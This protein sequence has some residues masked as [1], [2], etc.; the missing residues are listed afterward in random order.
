MKLFGIINQFKAYIAY[1]F[2]TIII[3]DGDDDYQSLYIV[4]VSLIFI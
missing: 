3:E 1:V 2:C 4:M